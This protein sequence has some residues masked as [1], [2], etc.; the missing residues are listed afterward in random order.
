MPAATEI[1]EFT[2]NITAL[3]QAASQVNPPLKTLVR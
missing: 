3:K 1:E 2:V